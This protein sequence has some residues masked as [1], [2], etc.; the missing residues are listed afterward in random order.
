M[1]LLELPDRKSI[2]NLFASADYAPLA[3][4]RK[5]AAASRLIAINPLA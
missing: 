4:Q 1:I 3:G 5:S 2:E